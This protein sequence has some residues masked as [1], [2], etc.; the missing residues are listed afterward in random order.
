MADLGIAMP[1]KLR[2]G[3]ALLSADLNVALISELYLA[4]HIS[5]PGTPDYVSAL[6]DSA[7]EL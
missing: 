5:Q 7:P 4:D 1:V 3:F 6:Q 2:Q